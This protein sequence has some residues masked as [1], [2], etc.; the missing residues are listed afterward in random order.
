MEVGE[1]FEAV[2]CAE[3]AVQLSAT[4]TTARQTLGRAQLGIGEIH[5]VSGRQIPSRPS[6]SAVLFIY[7]H[8]VVLRRRFILIPLTLNYGL[9]TSSG[10]R[11]W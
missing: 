6:S 2:Q 1:V 5:L 7:R 10:H 8:F 9:R 11:N 4:W 3:K